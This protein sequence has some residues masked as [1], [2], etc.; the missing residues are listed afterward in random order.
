MQPIS[1][2]PQ[3][4]R[5]PPPPSTIEDR[6]CPASLWL[7]PDQWPVVKYTESTG[8]YPEELKVHAETDN[9]LKGI[10]TRHLIVHL[11]T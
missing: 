9:I 5:V 3:L 4:V 8:Q 2:L 1:L 10:E 6:E 7:R 11:Y